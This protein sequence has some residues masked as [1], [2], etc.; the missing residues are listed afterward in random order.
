[1][2]FIIKNESIFCVVSTLNNLDYGKYSR[3]DIRGNIFWLCW[4]YVIC[5]NYK[6]KFWVI[7]RGWVFDKDEA[8]LEYI[9]LKYLL[10]THSTP[11]P[12]LLK[13]IAYTTYTVGPH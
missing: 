5:M 7:R 8:T 10:C 11:Q 12:Q 4:N 3:D 13:K 6:E 1:M 2:N 9:V